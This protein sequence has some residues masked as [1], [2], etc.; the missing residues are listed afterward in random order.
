M[1]VIGNRPCSV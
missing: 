1:T